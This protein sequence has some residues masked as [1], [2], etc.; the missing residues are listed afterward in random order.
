MGS[1]EAGLAHAPERPER[2]AEGQPLVCV[3]TPKA[4]G[5]SLG[6]L[7]RE[8]FGPTLVTDYDENPANPVGPRL[9]DPARHLAGCRPLP[10][11]ARCVHGH[12]HPG[13]Y[14]LGGAF[15]VTILREPVDNLLSI[16]FFWKQMP[17]HD[18]PLHD[19]LHDYFLDHDLGIV[20]TA[21]LPLLRRLLSET[22]YGG[23]D[24]RR[25]DLV[26]R[27]DDREATLERLG[28][29]VG[30]TFD[31]S[32]WEN[33]TPPSP[34][35]QAAAADQALRRRLEALLADDIAFYERHAR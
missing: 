33:R 14:D 21:R 27:H 29:H 23:F 13:K 20:E 34:E 16:Y 19:P 30:A 28:R 2:Q 12:F 32:V 18:D 26:G 25:F 5:W 4:G 7:L 6:R 1:N 17:R 15:L 31:V 24:M 10:P 35:R 3:H 11:G 22:Y 9:L 8:H